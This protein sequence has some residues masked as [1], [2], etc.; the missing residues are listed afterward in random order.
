MPALS[1]R[2]GGKRLGA[3]FIVDLPERALPILQHE[4][5]RAVPGRRNNLNCPGYNNFC[6]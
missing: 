4:D 2:A 3:R 6:F 5:I 1:S